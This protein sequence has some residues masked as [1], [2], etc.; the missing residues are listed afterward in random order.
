MMDDS[1]AR[2]TNLGREEKEGTGER[3][4]EGEG[5]R[6]RREG[7]NIWHSSCAVYSCR[8]MVYVHV[9]KK[10]EQRKEEGGRGRGQGRERGC[11]MWSM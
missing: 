5:E 10:E 8:Y 9:K 2:S 11:A 4:R 3:R 6:E 7:V 1:E